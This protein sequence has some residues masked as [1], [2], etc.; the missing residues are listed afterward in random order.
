MGMDQEAMQGYAAWG[1]RRVQDGTNDM[2]VEYLSSIISAMFLI[3]LTLLD[4]FSLATTA[5]TSQRTVLVITAYQIV[6]ELFLDFYVAFMENFC[7]LSKLH[8]N[9]WDPWAEGNPRSNITVDRWG[10]IGKAI[11]NKL[12]AT[13]VTLSLVILATVK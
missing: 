5:E 3:M 12:I 10:D 7:G 9:Y 11:V 1:K 8:E 4:A 13:I 6:P 2:L